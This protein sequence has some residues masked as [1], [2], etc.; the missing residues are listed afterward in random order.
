MTA[1]FIPAPWRDLPDQS[2][3]ITAARLLRF[4]NT[5]ADLVV[6][7]SAITG[8]GATGRQLLG[9]GTA[10]QAR[11]ILQ[12]PSVTDVNNRVVN[13]G[14]MAGLMWSGT[15]PT[16]ATLTAAGVLA[17]TLVASPSGLAYFTGQALIPV[18]LSS[19][20][21]TGSAGLGG[22]GSLAVSSRIGSSGFTAAL[23]GQGFF[24]ASGVV[25]GGLGGVAVRPNGTGT[26]RATGA[27]AAF[28]GRYDNVYDDTYGSAPA[29][30]PGS[31]NDTYTDTYGT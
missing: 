19:G 16:A 8:A 26:L 18:G 15:S 11:T 1:P 3:P 4:E 6:A 27:V 20:P 2:T 7:L 22:V 12:A 29:A 17:G 23:S 10:A 9:A 31:Y 25:S 5:L 21:L 14:S 30:T 28:A 24:T 13:V